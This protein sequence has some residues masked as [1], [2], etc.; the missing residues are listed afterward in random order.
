MDF[1]D[2]RP[3][4]RKAYLL[5]FL[6]AALLALVFVRLRFLD[7][8][9][10]DQWY[11]PVNIVVK[12]ST[13]QLSWRDLFALAEGHR[14]LMIRLFA[15]AGTLLFK[16]DPALMSL[17]TWLVSLINLSVIYSLFRGDPLAQK[18]PLKGYSP[19]CL[20][21]LSS[22]VFVIHD[23]QAWIDYYFATWQLSLCFFLCACLCLQ[24]LS[25]W[26]AFAG[27]AIF[28]LAS[29]FSLGIGLASWLAI[30]VVAIGYRSWRKIH[31]PVA[32]TA[33]GGATLYAY[34]SS[35]ANPLNEVSGSQR[36][37]GLATLLDANSWIS[38]IGILAKYLSSFC[39]ACGSPLRLGMARQPQS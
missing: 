7:I 28:C 14:P 24:R 20:V 31:F 5:A 34:Q 2:S 10:G 39:L 27:A 18:T 9:V 23:Q 21:G 22:V 29:T 19:L 26:N 32:W 35:L 17:T 12:A 36:M 3:W 37:Q 16:L 13:N 30:P 38:L 15:L 33:L 4:I 11:D 1:V 25:S 6:P 8:P